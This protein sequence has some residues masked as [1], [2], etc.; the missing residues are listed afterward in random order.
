MLR[1]VVIV[2]SV[3]GQ[4]LSMEANLLIFKQRPDF[5]IFPEYFNVDP[6]RRDPARNSLVAVDYLEYC[7]T[8]SDRFDTTLIAGTAIEAEKTAFYNTCHIFTRG[9]RIGIYRK[10]CP[11]KNE[12]HY[13]ISAGMSSGVFEIDGIRFALLIC[14][15]VLK[16]E[17]FRE[18][19]EHNPDIIFVPA[20][21]PLRSETVR[22]KFR[23]DHEIFVAG[24]EASGAYVVKCCA[25][26]ELWG[27]KL[28][29]R[30]LVAAPWCVL[31]RVSPDEEYRERLLTCVLDIDELREFK[32]KQLSRKKSKRAARARLAEQ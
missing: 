9:N 22:E 27:G 20:T 8:L 23:R 5:V 12:R 25:V 31:A 18:L 6:E 26:G 13:G 17:L 32:R 3:V 1:K 2:Q 28:Q 15:D 21:S 19:G 29:G 7:K 11:T 16:P 14:A 4:Q 24:A 10:R 30:S